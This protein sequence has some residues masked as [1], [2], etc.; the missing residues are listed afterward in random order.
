MVRQRS[1]PRDHGEQE[2]LGS[3]RPSGTLY[4]VGT[5]IGSPDD[6]TIRA[7]NILKSVSFI[8]A[9]TPL[10]TQA[11]LEHHGISATVTS[12]GPQQRDEKISLL[13]DRLRRGQDIA[14]VSDSGMPVVFD[15]GRLLIAAAHQA[16]CPVRII[17][18]PSALTAAVAASGYTGDR[19][20]FEG[21]LPRTSRRLDNFLSQLRQETRTVVLF[22]HSGSISRI[23]DRLARLVPTRQVTLAVDLT[24]ATEAVYRGKSGTLLKQIPSV[25]RDAEVTL[26]IEGRKRQR[27]RKQERRGPGGT[28]PPRGGG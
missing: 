18:G 27:A 25:G 16:D 15:P 28:S 4:I 5:P 2:S 26:V 7:I 8:A 1:Q 21:R 11:L 12:Y 20:I 9:E 3:E 22:A 14:L 24:T 19:I 23:L 13:L 6:L 17:P 10:A